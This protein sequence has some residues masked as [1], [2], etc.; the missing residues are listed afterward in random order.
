MIRIA[1]A[2]GLVLLAACNS[3]SMPGWPKP[4]PEA[5]ANARAWTRPGMDAAAVESA[6][7]DCRDVTDTATKTD[8]DIDQD[9]AS[10]RSS[11][12]QHSDFARTQM[13]QA[14]DTS[15]GRAQ[16]VLSSCMEAKG[17]SPAK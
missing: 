14:R 12:L 1:A 3:M 11:D 2:L 17:F 10:S 15:R 8:F 16:A 13:R 5:A 4:P 7:N 6:F 9:I